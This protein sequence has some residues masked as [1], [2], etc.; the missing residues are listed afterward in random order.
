MGGGTQEQSEEHPSV[1]TDQLR[2]FIRAGR[3]PWIVKNGELGFLTTLGCESPLDEGADKR[4][5]SAK[6][7]A[8]FAPGLRAVAV[9]AF[10][11][12]HPRESAKNIDLR[13]RPALFWTPLLI[14][15]A[16]AVLVFPALAA[17]A[18]LAGLSIYFI[19]V[20][21]VRVW[22]AFLARTQMDASAS[23]P[24]DDASL[25]VVTILAPLYREA[26]ALPGLV[27]AIARLD[28]P[29]AKIDVKLLLEQSDHETIDEARRLSLDDRFD[30]IIVPPSQPQTKPKA[31]NY[32][33]ALARGDLIVIYDAEDEPDTDQL[34]VAAG[35]F[36]GA[37][38]NLACV[39]ARLNYYNPDDNL[40][41]RLF[42]L[43]YCLWF[44]HFLPALDRLG[45]PVPLGGTSNI[46][47]T[48][49]L[50]EVG[51]WDPFNVTEDADLGLRL[52]RRGYRTAVIDS[53]TF[54][55]ANCKI[56][57]WMRQRSRWMKGFMQTWLVDRRART[58]PR[59][60]RDS[61]SVDFFIGG[62]VFAALINPLL[63]A[64]SLA[65]WI[66]GF[67]FFAPLPARLVD[68]LTLALAMGNVSF[69]AL[70]AFA[71][72][73]RGLGRLSPTALLTPVYW[74]MMSLAA[75][76][77]LW[78]LLRRPFFWEKT[79]HGL[80]DEAKLRRA[81]AL[82]AFGLAPDRGDRQFDAR[83]IDAPDERARP[84]TQIE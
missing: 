55:E 51:G 25:P 37:P 1:R 83:N 35:A 42:T 48:D 46:F 32:G 69:I 62:A 12:R 61:L 79:D 22:L 57:N 26:H 77:A 11:D 40:L 15:F 49:I 80:S 19:A 84:G 71:P 36:A 38:D 64:A 14:V 50:V 66:F 75:W 82:S 68:G 20:A 78:Q 2:K 53:T 45:A 29:A 72:L 60:W 5:F 70:G 43:E 39:Q 31:C 6:I 4:T 81:A 74:V 21:A 58:G 9:D 73:R 23:P 34:R 59:G 17:A 30:L 10:A 47:R 13:N 27:Q 76:I 18:I 24:V 7:Q 67:E 8:R 63:W 16:A 44:D 33:L 54:E 28:Y 65:K 3:I 52:A 56:G 41:T